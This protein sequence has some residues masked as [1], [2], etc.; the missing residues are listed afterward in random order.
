MQVDE[1]ADQMLNDVE[2][3]KACVNDLISLLALPAIWSGG[4]PGQIVGSLID[5]LFGMLRLDFACALISDAEENPPRT[6]IKL[7]K[8]E[9]S[10][11][12]PEILRRELSPWLSEHSHPCPPVLKLLDGN[13]FSLAP[14]RFGL[15]QDL[16]LIVVGSL[17]KGFP[18]PAEKLL[19]SVAANQA[20]IS[21]QDDRI[22]QQ[23]KEIARR[24]DRT[25][26]QAQAQLSRAARVATAA[27]LSA[28][29]A[30]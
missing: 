9:N 22:L 30:H 5:V 1:T 8:S 29:I 25:V 27:Q 16:G 3:L 17:R 6:I 2:S 23:H 15:K 24:L 14:I 12:T 18:N 4:E 26:V 19:L 28:S 21:L 7:A 10:S 20:A 13:D 11:L